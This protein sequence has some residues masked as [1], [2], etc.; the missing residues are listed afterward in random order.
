MILTIFNVKKIK[1]VKTPV[2]DALF[3]RRLNLTSEKEKNVAK[4]DGTNILLLLSNTII[5]MNHTNWG[6]GGS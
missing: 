2:W 4:V 6:R 1:L 5:K 3:Q